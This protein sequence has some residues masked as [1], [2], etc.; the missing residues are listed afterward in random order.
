MPRRKALK[1]E[2]CDL[3][4]RRGKRYVVC[5]LGVAVR[6]QVLPTAVAER[7]R[8][9]SET[10]L[11]PVS[12][13]KLESLPHAIFLQRVSSHSAATSL[14]GRLGQGAF[15]ALRLVD[16]LVP[17]HPSASDDAFQDRKS[18]VEGKSV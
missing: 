9:D 3:T 8:I 12:H 6:A 5:L 1:R 17:G 2:K 11:M 15:L 13:T 10:R 18:V 4:R 16:L 14:E 7:A